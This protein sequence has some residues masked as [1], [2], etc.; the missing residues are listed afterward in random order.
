MTREE[1]IQIIKHLKYDRSIGAYYMITDKDADEIIKALEQEPCE[2]AISRESVLRLFA[3]HDGKYLYEAIRELPP[4][5]P[6]PKTEVLDK[7][8]AEINGMYRVIFKGMP[9]DDWSVR[10][11]DCLDEVLQIIDKY[12][13]ESEDKE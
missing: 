7:I 5:Q 4:V 8:R 2:D 9:K 13:V 1:R 12:K 6:E 10:W 3:T 11:N